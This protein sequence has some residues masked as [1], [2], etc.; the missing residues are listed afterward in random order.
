M[1]GD[2]T[3]DI[4]LYTPF[5][6]YDGLI[7]LDA[8]E[9]AYNLPENILLKFKDELNNL[10]FNRYPDSQAT[11][12]CLAFADSFG[13]N[14]DNVIASNGSDELLYLILSSSIYK[15]GK[16][17][18]TDPDFS[19]YSFYSQLGENNVI[20]FEKNKDYQI[21]I[22]GFKNIIAESNP[23]III[24]SNPCN[25][26]GK[27]LSRSLLVDILKTTSALLIVDEAYM[28]FSLSDESMLP[29]V[30]AYD[31]LMVL[32]TLSKAF[33]CAAAR[34][35]FAVSGVKNINVLKALKSPYNLNSISQL[36]GR[37]LLTEGDIVGQHVMETVVLRNQMLDFLSGFNS[38][39]FK[40]IPSCTNFI[41]IETCFA[42]QIYNKML[43]NNVLI[44]CLKNGIRVTIGNIE[45]CKIFRDV[46]NKIAEELKLNHV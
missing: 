23:E 37:I 21:D 40:V 5:R 14:A 46:F 4:G 20:H 31:N 13:V 1:F 22:V 26:S 44:R 29:L 33:G 38:D 17:L 24:F 12:L 16:I 27:C 6:Y 11:E 45:E 3:K 35:G 36:L 43:E 39:K 28:D 32:K 41:F 19:M 42:S 34:I 8:N 10:D 15:G 18:V 25:P 2:K 7:R 30:K 9:S